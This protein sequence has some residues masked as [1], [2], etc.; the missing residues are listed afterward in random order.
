MA[1]Y[2]RTRTVEQAEAILDR[3]AR[4]RGWTP[5]VKDRAR[6]LFDYQVRTPGAVVP[7]LDMDRLPNSA[8]RPVGMEDVPLAKV[9]TP[10]GSVSVDAVREKLRNPS[11]AVPGL[12]WTAPQVVHH[13]GTYYVSDG[14]HRVTAARL[15]REPSIRAQVLE[16][17]NHGSN[18]GV[19]P[20]PEPKPG[21]RVPRLGRAGLVGGALGAAGAFGYAAS[22]GAESEPVGP[23]TPADMTSAGQTTEQAG[24]PSYGT[25]QDDD[26]RM[27]LAR[28]L[29]GG[30]RD[31]TTGDVRRHMDRGAELEAMPGVGLAKWL[32]PYLSDYLDPQNIPARAR[33]TAASLVDPLNIP[34][35]AV[36]VVS[37]ETRDHWRA[38]QEESPSG[39][40]AGS[41]AGGMAALRMAPAVATIPRSMGAGAAA[42]AAPDLV[43]AS[44]GNGTL[45]QETLMKAAFGAAGYPMR[46]RMPA[47]Q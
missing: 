12:A 6:H 30:P 9:R 24:M 42:G 39:R 26:E 11:S 33:S 5:D 3:I 29:A 4:S 38:A 15:M 16:L 10:Q 31:V 22:T 23:T 28:I 41:V 17:P 34:S 40:L 37:P 44:V 21:S 36:G 13:Q 35:A 25:G 8:F 47:R 18:D 43:D 1:D 14:N 7:P 19:R 27:S 46:A 20:P 45:D 2:S 32:A